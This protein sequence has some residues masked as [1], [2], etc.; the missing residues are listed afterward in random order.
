MKRHNGDI[1]PLV[2][3]NMSEVQYV[4]MVVLSLCVCLCV[5]WLTLLLRVLQVGVGVTGR[6]GDR[7]LSLHAQNSQTAHI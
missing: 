2:C 1:V 4:M 6:P 7:L 5:G 3:D